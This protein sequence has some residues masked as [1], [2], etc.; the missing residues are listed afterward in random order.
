MRGSIGIRIGRG[1]FLA[2][3]AVLSGTPG[4]AAARGASREATRGLDR[5]SVQQVIRVLQDDPD[6]VRERLERDGGFRQL[7]DE[8]LDASRSR[9]AGGRAMVGLGVSFMLLSVLV[10]TPLWFGLEDRTPAIAVW[11]A[12]GG[13]G[14]ALFVPG[15]AV[16]AN[17]SGAERTLI[18]EWQDRR[19]DWLRPEAH[20]GPR[21]RAALPRSWMVQLWSARF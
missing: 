18:R 5:R 17:P 3:V 16:M 13:A 8:Y 15:V 10:G 1:M 12:V 6:L 20:G 21:N 2:L 19:L 11:G 14:F 9:M 7:A 4:M